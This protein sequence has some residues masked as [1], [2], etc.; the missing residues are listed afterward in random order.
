M[1]SEQE[2]SRSALHPFSTLVFDRDGAINDPGMG[3]ICNMKMLC[4][5]TA[6]LKQ[7]PISCRATGN[8]WHRKQLNG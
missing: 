4:S 1:L 3:I 5:F 6:I 7:T 8:S 2:S